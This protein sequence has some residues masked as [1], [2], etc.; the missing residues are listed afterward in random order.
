GVSTARRNSAL[1]V[2]LCVSATSLVWIITRNTNGGAG[3]GLDTLAPWSVGLKTPGRDRPSK[4]V[5]AGSHWVP[6]GPEQGTGSVGGGPQE[7][8]RRA[9]ADRQRRGKQQEARLQDPRASYLE[10]LVHVQQKQQEQQQQQQREEGGRPEDAV[11]VD[12]DS[13]DIA[14]AAAPGDVDPRWRPLG[15]PSRPDKTTTPAAAAAAGAGGGTGGD[16]GDNGFG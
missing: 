7:A 4:S 14:L 9:A 10:K 5:R 15:A 11:R 12:R 16:A 3:G 8:F 13:T 6:T 2:A 1:C